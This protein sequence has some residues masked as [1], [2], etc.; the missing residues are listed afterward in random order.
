LIDVRV[1]TTLILISILIEIAIAIE[2]E[3][4]I[5]F[6]VKLEESI[7]FFVG[8]RLRANNLKVCQ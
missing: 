7:N 8:K 5:N 3:I 2:I 6:H 4:G 1:G